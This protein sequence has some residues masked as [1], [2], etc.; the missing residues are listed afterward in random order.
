M[1]KK[2]LNNFKKSQDC[3]VAAIANWTV[4][5]SFSMY[6]VPMQVIICYCVSF[7]L[8]PRHHLPIVFKPYAFYT[9]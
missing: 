7:K 9:F 6:T 3:D 8:N 1:L 5:P 4:F 2:Q